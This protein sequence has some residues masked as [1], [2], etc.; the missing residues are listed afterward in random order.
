MSYDLFFDESYARVLGKKT[1]KKDFFAIFYQ[2]FMASSPDIAL[3]FI[4]TNLEKQGQMLKKSFYSLLVFYASN[5]ADDYLERIATAHNR[6]HLNI[7]PHYYDLWLETLI[8]TVQE[9]DPMFDSN[10]E[11]AWRLVLSGGITYM[12]FKY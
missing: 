5:S 11:L 1:S 4:N 8:E 9:C 12:K 3:M 2:K 6:S 7:P 10:T